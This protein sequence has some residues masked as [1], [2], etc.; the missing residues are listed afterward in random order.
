M[1]TGPTVSADR[2]DSLDGVRTIAVVAVMLVHCGAPGADLGWL[3]VDLFFVLSGF[4]IT[5]LLVQEHRKH[6]RISLPKFW[7]RRF[8]RLMPASWLY[9]G[10]LTVAIALHPETLK[11]HEGWSPSSYVASLWC[12]F[13]N[14]L[15]KGG[16]WEHQHLSLHLWSLAVE[17][18]FYLVWPLVLGVALRWRRAWLVAWFAV[19]AVLVRRALG[20][21]EDLEALLP[22]RGIGI[23]LGCAAALTAS[24]WPRPAWLGSVRV[25]NTLLAA[26]VLAV[27]VLTALRSRQVL[28]DL[29]LKSWALVF[30][31]AAFA[32]AVTMLWYGTP[33]RVT[34]LLASRPMVYIGRVSYGV[35]LYH[36]AV[37]LFVWDILTPGLSTASRYLDFGLRTAL[38]LALTL[39]AAALSH[40][41]IEQPFLKLKAR[42]R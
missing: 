40:R 25:R 29:E 17:E 38:Y 2:V 3:G 34:A 42:L 4:L 32:L 19:A 9:A 35:Y 13:I 28:T 16:I 15:P 39:G 41:L 33:D 24:S 6:G 23:V 20:A 36:I 22:T 5:T 30:L 26:I 14:Y 7:G 31:A 12:Y 18:Q 21:P 27:A 10:A 11:S 1:S 8:L 37:R